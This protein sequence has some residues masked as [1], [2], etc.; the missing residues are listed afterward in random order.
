MDPQAGREQ[1]G[2][3]PALVL[4][5][6]DYNRKSSLV[7][8]C[9]LT[10]KAKGYPFEVPIEASAVVAGSVTGV[11]L[12]DQVKSLD[13]AARKAE[14]F[15][16]LNDETVNQVTGMILALIDPDGVFGTGEEDEA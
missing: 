13:W 3:R 15:A 16:E 14:Y 7:V 10:N 9:P 12:A 2:R 6:A 5:P 4:S 11:I 1:A 8:V